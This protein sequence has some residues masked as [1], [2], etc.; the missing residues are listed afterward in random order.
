MAATTDRTWLGLPSH[1]VVML[2]ASTAAY[3]L[4]LA[5]VAG[6]QS[7]NEAELAALRAP[8]VQGLDAL[9]AGHDA[10]GARLEAAQDAY[11]AAVQAY[12]D[13]GGSLATVEANLGAFAGVV[14][15]IDGASRSMPTS[16]KLPPV[17]RASS[18][19]AP[20]TQGTTGASGG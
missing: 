17:Q 19:K 3:A 6:L 2:G 14:A 10:I 4:V 16:V 1:V 8:A 18:A 15:Q 9:T 12:A 7:R 11:N 5:G 20:K 13:A